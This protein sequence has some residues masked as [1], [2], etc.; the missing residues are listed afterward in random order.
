MWITYLEKAFRNL[1]S[2]KKCMSSH[3]RKCDACRYMKMQNRHCKCARSCGGRHKKP[4]REKE[5][6]TSNAIKHGK[7]IMLSTALL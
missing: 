5:S 4:K 1:K 2:S 7:V 6:S 3:T